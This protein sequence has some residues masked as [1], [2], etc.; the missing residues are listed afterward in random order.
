MLTP[1]EA[2]T[3][4]EVEVTQSN[5]FTKSISLTCIHCQAHTASPCPLLPTNHATPST[6]PLSP[7]VGATLAWATGSRS[8]VQSAGRMAAA[9]HLAA[10]WGKIQVVSEHSVCIEYSLLEPIYGPW[11]QS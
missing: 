6:R 4:V 11:D 5:I 2:T 7:T 8:T 10:V 9:D 1:E 3:A